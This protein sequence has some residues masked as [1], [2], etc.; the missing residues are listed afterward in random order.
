MGALLVRPR[1][2]ALLWLRLW[3]WSAA[4]HALLPSCH[5]ERG[6]PSWRYH[7]FWSGGLHAYV[8]QMLPQ[9]IMHATIAALSGTHLMHSHKPV[10]LWEVSTQM[11]V[12]FYMHAMTGPVLKARS[13]SYQGYI[14]EVKAHPAAMQRPHLDVKPPRFSTPSKHVVQI[15]SPFSR[16]C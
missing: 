11:R 16:S 1:M 3:A 13:R 2:G 15:H 6:C 7:P 8:S 12:D 14:E 9:A 4:P 5:I 10:N